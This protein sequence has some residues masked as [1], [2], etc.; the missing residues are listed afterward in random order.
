M[1]EYGNVRS[2]QPNPVVHTQGY[3]GHGP[4][5]IDLKYK[6]ICFIAYAWAAR[7]NTWLLI[8]LTPKGVVFS[9]LF[10]SFLSLLTDFML[11]LSIGLYNL[12][13]FL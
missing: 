8:K 1:W 12:M 11:P 13:K 4:T 9:F 2:Q 3:P 6:V 5:H 10:F 7:Y